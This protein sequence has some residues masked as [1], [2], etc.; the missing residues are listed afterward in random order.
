MMERVEHINLI[1]KLTY[2][3]E[4]DCHPELPY[5][6][7]E[8]ANESVRTNHILQAADHIKADINQTIEPTL[9]QR[10][11]ALFA[12]LIHHHKVVTIEHFLQMGAGSKAKETFEIIAQAAVMYYNAAVAKEQVHIF[13]PKNAHETLCQLKGR[14]QTVHEIKRGQITC[15]HCL[16]IWKAENHVS[17]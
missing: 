1:A 11:Q 6:P 4:R 5:P 17:S 12:E 13:A 14:S 7:W 8:E 15:G 3:A 9:G 10:T 2:Q 16:T